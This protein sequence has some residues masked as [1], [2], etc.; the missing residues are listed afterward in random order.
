MSDGIV[1]ELLLKI[2]VKVDDKEFVELKKQVDDLQK[3][4]ARIRTGVFNKSSAVNSLG[5]ISSNPEDKETIKDLA[6]NIKDSKDSLR[7]IA[8]S[9]LKTENKNNKDKMQDSGIDLVGGLGIGAILNQMINLSAVIQQKYTEKLNRD[10]NIASL[11]YET[12]LTTE[13]VKELGYRSKLVGVSL[14]SIVEN[15]KNFSNEVFEGSNDKQIALANALGIDLVG[16]LSKAKTPL[17]TARAQSKLYDQVFRSLLPTFGFAGASSRAS[18]V[19]GLSADEAFR[20]QRLNNPLTIAG[21]RELSAL[22]GP[23]GSRDEIF[24]N[25]Q[26]NALSLEKVQAASDRALS[27]ASIAKQISIDRADMQAKVV[28]IIADSL[29]GLTPSKD[30]QD[31]FNI[32]YDQK[33]TDN[34]F[35]QRRAAS[36]TKAGGG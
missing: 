28:T 6:D 20:Y 23:I 17:E 21:A 26:Q 13:S 18:Q 15:A 30:T 2:G 12:N 19:S 5:S 4:S 9:T 14:E 33:T 32:G 16:V 25:Y 3:G 7:K 36:I 35:K 34:Y 10:M 24:T 27:T 22:R 11:A 8:D 29:Q 31:F 1:D